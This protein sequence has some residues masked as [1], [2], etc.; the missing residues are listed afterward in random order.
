M[1]AQTGKDMLL[2][3]DSDGAG[4]FVTIGGLQAKSF[5]L[6]NS[7]VDITNDDSTNRWRELLAGAGVKSVS[8]SGTGV[9]VDDAAITTVVTYAMAD[10]QRDWQVIVPDLGTFE[11]AFQIGGLELSGDHDAEVSQNITIES[12]GAITFTA[13]V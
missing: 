2:K 11:G 12:A 3:V 6:N 8:A 13:A 9:F 1:A 7:Q 5:A 10:T 4:T